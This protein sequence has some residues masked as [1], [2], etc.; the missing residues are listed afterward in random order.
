M[1]PLG[2]SLSTVNSRNARDAESSE[3]HPD[4]Q[5]HSSSSLVSGKRARRATQKSTESVLRGH[6][7]V[8]NYATG[9][10]RTGGDYL[11]Y[12]S[13]VVDRII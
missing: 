2:R 1:E 5:A 13:T 8:H 3:S 6:D 10:F 9:M 7:T 12:R 11:H 4:G